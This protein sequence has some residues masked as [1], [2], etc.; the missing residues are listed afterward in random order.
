MQGQ[1]N[2][3]MESAKEAAASVSERV[4]DFFQGNPFATP[5]GHKIGATVVPVQ[6]HLTS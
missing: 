1:V 5:V 6:L 3:A 2:S 4:T